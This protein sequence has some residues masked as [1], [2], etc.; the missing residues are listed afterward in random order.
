MMRTSARMPD[1]AMGRR[2]RGLTLV[3]FLVA[4][5]LLGIIL[6][7]T[8]AGMRMGARSWAA[9]DA[10]LEDSERLRMTE[11]FLRRQVEQA[12]AV[13]IGRDEEH[14]L[15]FWGERERLR[16]VA[17]MPNQQGRL[18]GLYLYTL[19]F[20]DAGPGAAELELS[21]VLFAPDFAPGEMPEPEGRVILARDL[22]GGSFE[23]FGAAD[24]REAPGWV[25][26]WPREDR[27]PLLVR[28]VLERP[29]GTGGTETIAL[30]GNAP[31]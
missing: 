29:D 21:Y 10:V 11:G 31:R 1:R 27:L 5:S 14:R 18:A 20:R 26:Q 24:R 8:F 12:R 19:E 17:P 28:V 16:F 15:A 25:A 3:E 23:Y 22:A 6:A 7:L 13:S 9:A 4:L 30:H 2:N